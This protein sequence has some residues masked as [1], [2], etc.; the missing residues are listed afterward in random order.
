MMGAGGSQ[1]R[2]AVVL[3][4]ANDEARVAI[5]LASAGF[6]S[7]TIVVDLGS[8]DGSRRACEERG[9]RCLEPEGVARELERG[10]ARWVLLM[11][12]HEEISPRLAE[13][14]RAIGVR[15]DDPPETPAGY[16]VEREIRFLG[17]PVGVPAGSYGR[18][19][20]LF[21]R[22]TVLWPPALVSIET[23]SC[24]GRLGR[25]H[26]RLRAEPYASLHHY[27]ERID[28]MTSAV[29]RARY[30]NGRRAGWVDMALRPVWQAA[31]TL[32][33]AAARGRLA[34]IIFTLLEVYRNVVTAAKGW[35]I[36][37]AAER[38]GDAG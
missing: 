32:P 34:G 37:R 16:E 18:G 23:V 27:I 9:V 4:V 30:R 31:R 8:T 14:I 29:A 26:G 17:R 24:R 3:L 21:R 36:A 33:A 25:L 12:G 1:G 7:T 6:A 5:A 38:D 15:T 10:G 22:D 11:E 13:E 19:V 2:I 35:E 20:R 28:V